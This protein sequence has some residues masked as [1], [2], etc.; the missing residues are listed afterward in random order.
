VIRQSLE[1]RRF[2]W[3]N[4]T[5]ADSLDQCSIGDRTRLG[6]LPMT[7]GIAIL[8]DDGR[9]VVVASDRMLSS[10]FAAPDFHPAY[11]HIDA[12]CDK[13]KVV[14]DHS[15]LIYSGDSPVEQA[16]LTK[17]K[18]ASIKS[19]SEFAHEL[20]KDLALLRQELLERV[21]RRCGT[22]LE[23]VAAL[24]QSE[25]ELS[26]MAK[27]AKSFKIQGTFL[28]AGLDQTTAKI[29]TAEDHLVQDVA[30]P[31]FG[32]I[33]YGAPFAY[34]I[35]SAFPATRKMSVASAT[36]LAY[37]AKRVTEAAMGIG[38]QTQMGVATVGRGAK[39]LDKSE[40]DRLDEIYQRRK[41]LGKL[42][43]DAIAQIVQIGEADSPST[44]QS[45]MSRDSA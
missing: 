14:G 44:L 8:C 37:E 15:F 1:P 43:E 6:D 3:S 22:T 26:G 42:D 38:R 41:T 33:G 31:C 39:P 19:V 40:I 36:L 23:A 13:L 45:P 7:I 2:P 9:S 30:N 16:V 34:A 35:L 28:V 21:L 24:A 17:V 10:N 20:G 5:C 29:F 4:E 27:V 18:V 12:D 11:L 32:T 25:P